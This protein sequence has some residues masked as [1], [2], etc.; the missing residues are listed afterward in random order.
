MELDSTRR[1]DAEDP[2]VG[3]VVEAIGQALVVA[4]RDRALVDVG[5]IAQAVD[6]L[7]V[8]LGFRQPVIDP[9]HQ[10]TAA[11]VCAAY[12][13]NYRAHLALLRRHAMVRPW[14]RG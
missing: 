11:F 4:R 3:Q 7:L 9:V 6:F 5:A 1:I 2:R 8:G 10:I 14:S 12:C 13:F